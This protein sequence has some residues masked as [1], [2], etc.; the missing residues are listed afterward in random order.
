MGQNLNFLPGTQHCS[1]RFAKVKVW[2]RISLRYIALRGV[3]VY[4]AVF[5]EAP[6]ALFSAEC[7]VGTFAA[8]L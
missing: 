2:R 8:I 4:I 3:S 7:C 5:T 6:G 1:H